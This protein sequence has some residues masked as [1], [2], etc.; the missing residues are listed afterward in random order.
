MARSLLLV[1]TL[2]PFAAGLIIG[3][4]ITLPALAQPASVAAPADP[5]AIDLEA[6]P[7]KPVK[8][9]LAVKGVGDDDDA[10]RLGSG[11]KTEASKSLDAEKSGKG[12]DD[13]DF[14]E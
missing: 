13:G 14:D 8:G 9:P 2:A 6:I 10:P 4:Q 11:G 3:S 7:V 5:A 1:A 12:E